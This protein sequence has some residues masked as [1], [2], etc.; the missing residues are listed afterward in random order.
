MKVGEAILSYD[1][2]SRVCK[3]KGDRPA[4]GP[5]HDFEQNIFP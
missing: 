3:T 5:V 4:L 2:H 1:P